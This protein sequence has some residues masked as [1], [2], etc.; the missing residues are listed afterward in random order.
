MRVG[1]QL[2]AKRECGASRGVSCERIGDRGR[3]RWN[4]AST[5]CTTAA[6]ASIIAL[7]LAG[8][9]IGPDFKPPAAPLAR[10]WQELHGDAI[11]ATRLEYRDWWSALDD[12]VLT[13]L[14]ELAYRQNLTLLAAGVRVLQARAQLGVAI[15]ELYP[16]QQEASAALSY[17]HIPVSIPYNVVS[18]T[19]WQAAFGLQAGW[20]ID[21]WGKVRRGIESADDAFLASVADY[22]DVL[23]TLT[24][25]VASTYV[26]MRTAEK[27]QA[28]ARANI[29]RQKKAL[30]IAQARFAG[31]VVTKRDV[32]Q[33]ENVLGAT[34]AAVPQLNIEIQRAKNALS[35]LLGM[36]P[37]SVDALLGESSG[38]PV[39]PERIAVGIPA[40]L[41]RRRPDVRKAELDAAAQCAQIGFAKGD[42]LPAFSLVGNLGTIATD[43]GQADLGKVF[44]AGNLA[45]SAG[46]AVQ[47]NI[48]NYG[49]ISNNV[50]VQDA[51]FQTLLVEYQ[52][53]V[54][55]AQQEVENGITEFAQSRVQA[56][57][58]Q[59]SVA[60]AEGALEIAL[61]EYKGGTVDFTV[62]LTAEQN[63]YQ[64]QNS[65][66]VAQGNIPLGLVKAY[67]A[68]GGGWELREGND[69]VP[70]ATREEM[71]DR[72][73]WGTL[74]APELLRPQ[75]PGLPSPDDEGPTV[76]PPEW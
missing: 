69:F 21:V 39:A 33:A 54:L 25:D 50:R 40:D 10:Q 52:H 7:A 26:K 45:Y 72:T 67:R 56:G 75:A 17:N 28:I 41:L 8:C 46:P 5:R 42:L 62:V 60:A 70:T 23:V 35:T 2:T 32:Y 63:L 16:Q 43:V 76:R 66:A 47:W 19:Y 3:L 14:I 57:F 64:A 53:A 31:G 51:K 9:M 44:S 65:L 48:L 24:G 20:E 6:L 37:G 71:A 15:G 1:T 61:L 30:A 29:V 22:D 34:E 13:Q 49:Q 18:N 12:P 38:I 58:L 55:E 36:P 59:Q 4:S 73:D 27:Q 68:L 11:D 74:L